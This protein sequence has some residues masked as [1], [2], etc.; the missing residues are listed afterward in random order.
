[1]VSTTGWRFKFTVALCCALLALLTLG[2]AIAVGV[3]QFRTS[4]DVLARVQLNNAKTAQN[5]LFAQRRSDLQRASASMATN[6]GFIGYMAKALSPNP[7]TGAIDIA[8]IRDL[9]DERRREFHL[10]IAAI[11]S[12]AGRVI[13]ASGDASL[14][15]NNLATD[16]MLRDAR[17]TISYVA[18]IRRDAQGAQLVAFTPV[19]SGGTLEAW[20]L[21][22]DGLNS[23]YI[24]NLANVTRVDAALVVTD[25]SG[26]TV[27]AS[28]L[29]QDTAAQLRNALASTPLP[30]RDNHRGDI[31]L[32]LGNA[33][34]NAYIAY[35]PD[36][37]KNVF[38]VLLQP[39][40]EVN[41]MRSAVAVSLAL[42]VAALMLLGVIFT[43][44]FW[45]R[46]VRPLAALSRLCDYSLNG[47]YALTAG[48]SAS[49]TI[50]HVNRAF[51]HVLGLV[52]TYRPKPG[53]P[54]R[55]IADRK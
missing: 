7:V 22:G 53:A 1:M 29:S 5:Y 55:R 52:D 21:T 19:L 25:Q 50:A 4:V 30:D 18:G 8:S 44:V 34:R 38:V 54:A 51:N 27:L 36:S 15:D 16:P 31:K 3:F 43:L 9:L 48:P 23:T 13:A 14:D 45:L 2:I 26:T 35:F 33:R 41:A 10:G 17:K 46:F 42:G 12:P 6:P 20:L 32:N 40:T 11:V 37:H 49:R 47:D 28:N 39:I 24:K